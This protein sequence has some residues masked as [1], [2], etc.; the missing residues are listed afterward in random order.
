M[1]EKFTPHFDESTIGQKMTN[2]EGVTSFSLLNPPSTE[3][4]SIGMESRT[5]RTSYIDIEKIRQENAAELERI[6]LEYSQKVIIKT[7][8][9]LKVGIREINNSATGGTIGIM[10]SWSTDANWINERGIAEALALT[11]PGMKVMFIETPGMGD[12]DRLSE[13]KRI[14]LLKTGSFKPMGEQIAAAL[15]MSNRKI[16]LLVGISEGGRGAISLAS[17]IG[18]KKSSL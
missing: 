11:F 7:P 5:G 18:A 3:E 17:E 13:E 14:E 16:D 15:I 4:H 1:K 8:D 10:T 6:S 2:I 12:S 9:G